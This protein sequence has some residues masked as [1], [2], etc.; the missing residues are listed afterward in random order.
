MFFEAINGLPTPVAQL[1]KF[2]LLSLLVSSSG[3]LIGEM[4]PRRVYD[5]KAFPFKPFEWEMSGHVYAKIGIQYWKGYVPDISRMVKSVFS[6]RITNPRDPVCILRLI[7]ETCNGEIVHY[8]MMLAS[9]IFLCVLDG[10]YGIVGMFLFSVIGNFPFAIIQRYNRP[11]LI[12]L[13][14]RLSENQHMP[15]SA[16]KQGETI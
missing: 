2:L 4:I 15:E 8:L 5:Y 10:Y 13:M 1:I 12:E 11:R 14:E 16:D 7:I 3:F 6:K 9:P